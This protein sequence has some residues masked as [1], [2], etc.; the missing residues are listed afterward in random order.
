MNI[1]DHF[2]S[3]EFSQHDG[4]PYPDQ[5][6]DSRLRPLCAMLEELRGEIGLPI[7]VVS[8]YRSEAYNR[9]LYASAGKPATD[10]QHTYGR[11]ADIKIVGMSGPDICD[12]VERMLSEGRLALL[13]GRGVYPSFVHLDIRPRN[14]DHIARWDETGGAPSGGNF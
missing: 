10:S 14:G 2:D 13:G 1:T 8:G 5:W 7:A 11:A 6:I 9:E 4:E 12:V 3:N